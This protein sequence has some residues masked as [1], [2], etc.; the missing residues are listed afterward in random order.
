[1]HMPFILYEI[2]S[3]GKREPGHKKCIKWRQL[4]NQFSSLSVLHMCHARVSKSI[5]VIEHTRNSILK[6]R[7]DNITR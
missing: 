4:R 3:H 5:G 1:M 6:F 2:A 7:A